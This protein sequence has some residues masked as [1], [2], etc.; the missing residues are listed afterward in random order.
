[1][2]PNPYD[3][4]IADEEEKLAAFCKFA[5]ETRASFEARISTLKAMRDG[6]GLDD[7]IRKRIS[8]ST[9]VAVAATPSP[10]PEVAPPAPLP[11][12]SL[13]LQ[14][15]AL[16][17]GQEPPTRA[18]KG[19]AQLAFLEALEAGHQTIDAVR[20]YFASLGTPKEPGATR[21]GLWTLKNE[22]YV[23]NPQ[24][25]QYAITKEGRKRLALLRGKPQAK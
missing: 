3:A 16:S 22:G 11:E 14:D 20:E 9:P 23:E 13:R 15:G 8:A 21:T 18:R 7:F 2:S 24:A 10:E 5:E 4:L 17:D 12:F 1:M 25:G 6:D 19:Q